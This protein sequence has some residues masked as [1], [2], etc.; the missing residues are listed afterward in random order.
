MND[1]KQWLKSGDPA[2]G[3]PGLSSADAARMRR[4]VVAEVEGFVSPRLA[5]WWPRPL[6]MAGVVTTCLAI[7][8]SAGL[9]LNHTGARHSAAPAV[10]GP[11][12]R[13]QVQFVTAGGTRIIW[14]LSGDFD[15]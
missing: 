4:V 13:R 1:V 8:V 6:M 11:A 3:D 14:T 5:V 15:L 7:G 2:A 10:A 12:E 9:R